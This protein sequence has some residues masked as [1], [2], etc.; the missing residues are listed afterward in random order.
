MNDKTI[1]A[2][3]EA[4]SY[5]T[6]TTNGSNIDG[7]TTFTN[8]W[9]IPERIMVLENSDS[10]EFIYKETSLIISTVY[11]TR[12]PEERVFKIVFSC[13]NGKW[14]KSDRIYGK[15]IPSRSESYIFE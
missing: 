2:T 14:H 4:N 13:E 10:I 6:L 11:P 7:G 5:S 1:D 8:L 3:G 9:S 12:P 15:I